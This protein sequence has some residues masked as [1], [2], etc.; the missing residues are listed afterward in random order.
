M[1]KNSVIY[2]L[3]NVNKQSQSILIQRGEGSYVLDENGRRYL[4]LNSGLWNVPLGYGLRQ[5]ERIIAEQCHT[6]H[7]VNLI[8]ASSPKTDQFADEM[9]DYAGG[10]FVRL[11]YAC[12]GSEAVECA[13]KIA[14][15]YMHISGQPERKVILSFDMSYHGTTCAAMSVSG[16]VKETVEYAPLMEGV[17]FLRTPFFPG[18]NGAEKEEKEREEYLKD[19][20]KN[21]RE[22]DV[23]GVL[24]EPVMGSG[25]IISLP[26]WYQ[27][28]LFDLIRQYG[29]VL[30]AD[31]VATG[32]GRTGCKFAS[33][34]FSVNPD[35]LCLSK[36]VTNGI[37]PMGAVLINRRIADAYASK[38]EYINHFS[39][40]NGNPIACAIGCETLRL[41]DEKMIRTINRQSDQWRTL[42]EVLR[43]GQPHV[44]EIRVQGLM[45]A[46]DLVDNEEKPV[47]MDE[48]N[49]L[50]SFALR[51]GMLLYIF[52][53]PG[54]TAGLMLMPPYELT[55]EEIA[56]AVRALDKVIGS[57]G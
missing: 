57:I 22:Q 17:R 23:A 55:K 47:S 29:V 43:Q 46:I 13:V 18:I 39:T 35:L 15:K 7:Y 6:L 12:S 26:D 28:R 1:A 25:G 32:F 19:L 21:F 4:D 20:E 40:Q 5:Y 41:I 34:K 8:S 24:L 48:L 52:Q 14:R 11:V 49:L 53:C 38:N 31:E 2:P 45:I 54:R 36:A 33:E 50:E 10:G 27:T 44:R 51:Q 16:M 37:M 56:R 30:I 3:S 9:I 42:L